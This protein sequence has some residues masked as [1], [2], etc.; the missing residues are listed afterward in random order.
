MRNT[1]MNPV[2]FPVPHI[3]KASAMLLSRREL[4]DFSAAGVAVLALANSTRAHAAV[5]PVVE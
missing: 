3:E 1:V 2:L 5:Q 4:F